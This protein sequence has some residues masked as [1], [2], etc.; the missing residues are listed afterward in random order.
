MRL[1]SAL[2]SAALAAATLVPVSVATTS[3][4]AAA[5]PPGT[6]PVTVQLFEWEWADVAKE[7]T[8][9]LGPKGYGGVQVSPPMEHVV[10]P[11][12]GYPWWQRY[13]P[14]SYKIQG[15]SGSR[16]EFASMVATCHNAGVKVYVDAVINHMSGQDNGGTGSA[17]TAYKKYEYPGTYAYWDF[18]HCGRNGNDDI[19]NYGDAYEVQNCEL[20]N[21]ADL[22]TDTDYVRGRIASY[23]N[24]LLS[25]GVDGF[26]IDAAKHMPA[27]DIGN[28]LSRL[29][30]SAYS[31][32]E[33][34][35]GAGEPITPEQYTGIGDVLEFRYGRELG[36]QFKGGGKLS[37]LSNF[38][39]PWGFISSGKAV[40]FT[41][42]HDT[43]RSEAGHVLTYKDGQLYRLGNIF[44]LAWHYGAPKVMSSYAFSNNDQGPPSDGYGNTNA[45]TCFSGGWVCEHRYTEI[46]NMVGFANATRGTGVTNWW[47]NGNNAIA[48][49]RGSAGYVAIN[50]ESGPVTR[51]FQ[52]SLPAGTYCDVTRGQISGGTCTGRAFTVSS[53][54]T[55]A[56]TVG[57]MD[58]IALH[59]N[60]K[61]SN[62]TVRT[63]FNEYATTNVGQ[64]VYVVGSI[65]QLGSWSAARAVPLGSGGYPTWSATFQLPAS[66]SFTY[67]YIKK[68]AAGNVVWESD[69]KRSATTPSSGTLTTNDS[70]R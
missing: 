59:V 50:R 18:H 6:K 4:P 9:F 34:I 44:M 23:L 19:V 37:Y 66:T 62:T 32:S 49:G 35:H 69:P 12:N 5:S 22:A 17:G 25:L 10:L 14:V 7:C 70:W 51:T 43:Q 55:F 27:G 1:R 16:T 21:L 57:A 45:V 68:D 60:Q 20:V 54:G 47:S 67:K 38:G 58:A 41:D 24:D 42:N 13:Q 28:I 2:A 53:T 3:S 52:T 26:R 31:Y 64:N 15:C 29:N 39:E 48:F 30:R 40:V 8:N 46:A 56:A 63:T 61:V 65:S 11:G 33:V 36:K